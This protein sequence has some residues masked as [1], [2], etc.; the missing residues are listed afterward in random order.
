MV[1]LALQCILE[2]KDYNISFKS[3]LS[4]SSSPDKIQGWFDL[5]AETCVE[6]VPQE[7]LGQQ[8]ILA[9]YAGKRLETYS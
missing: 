1:C 8:E 5:S 4:R 2:F 6:K 9:L 3:L 7:I